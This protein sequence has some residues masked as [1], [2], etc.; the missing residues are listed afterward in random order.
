MEFSSS[1]LLGI[2]NSK[3][4]YS[5]ESFETVASKNFT[6]YCFRVSRKMNVIQEVKRIAEISSNYYFFLLSLKLIE[7]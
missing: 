6:V 7:F 1:N 3:K 5:V 2:S 4:E